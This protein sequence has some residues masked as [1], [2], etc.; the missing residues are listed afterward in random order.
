M[1]ARILQAHVRATREGAL[2]AGARRR[3]RAAE[4]GLRPV[5][6]L[7]AA[8]Q[9][10]TL[11]GVRA[12]RSSPP[13]C[14]SSIVPKGFFPVQDTGVIVGVTEAAADD[15]VR[16]PRRAAAGAG[17]RAARRPGGREP[18]VVRRRRRH[19]RDAEQRPPAD[20]PEA[21]RRARPTTSAT[22][23]RRLQARAARSSGHRAVPAGRCRTSRSRTASAARNTSTASSI[24]TGRSSRSGR[25]ACSTRC[26]ASPRCRTSP[27]T[28][29][30]AGCA[31][32]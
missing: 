30:P 16:G 11:R 10:A 21:A 8:R 29:R 2:G 3:V 1:C 32:T 27:P 5:A 17:R 19:E 28:S 18:V 24:R 15:L 26:G 14:C 23:M 22:V 4:G 7:G 6:D 20:Q 12:A 31:P 13:R 9:R 25:A